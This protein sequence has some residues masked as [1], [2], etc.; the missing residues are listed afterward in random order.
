LIVFP[1][2]TLFNSNDK[3]DNR[4]DSIIIICLPFQG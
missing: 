3:G 2:R 4:P 1:H